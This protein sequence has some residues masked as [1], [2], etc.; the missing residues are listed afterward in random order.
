[1]NRSLRRIPA[2][3]DG[4][5]TE[6]HKALDAAEQEAIQLFARALARCGASPPAMAREFAR[7]CAGIPRSLT[8]TGKG[9]Q[10][11]LLDASHVLTLWFSDPRYL[12]A[13][14]KPRLL[15]LT[16]SGPS[17]TSLTQRVDP[18]LDVRAVL[19]CLLKTRA[20]RKRGNRYAPGA[21]AVSFRGTGAPTYLRNFERLLSLL[22]ILE[23]NTRPARRVRGAFEFTAENPH[24]PRSARAGFGAR[25][26][27]AGMA[28][29]HEMDSAMLSC[30][31]DRK[32]GEPTGR[33]GVG[34]YLFDEG[35]EPAYSKE[36]D[37]AAPMNRRKR[38][39][40]NRVKS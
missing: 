24:F 37:R 26:R 40:R 12:G 36:A 18:A 6:R 7:V 5:S 32:P 31:R 19:K 38:R 2:G 21:R 28:Y 29:L 3:R 23:H 8:I 33:M 15:P 30:E 1:M 39:K 9:A 16:G 14:G 34:V 4:P 35:N 10:R 20:L 17:I 27:H 25:A 22:R 11:S 13:D